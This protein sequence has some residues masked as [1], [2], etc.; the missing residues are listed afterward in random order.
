MTLKPGTFLQ[1]RYEIL[2]IKGVGGMSVV[3]KARCHKLNRFVAIKVLKEEFAR[4]EAFVAK[5]KMEAQAAASL[6]HPNIVN[7]YDVVDD[8]DL[9]FIVMEYIEGVTLKT[10]IASRK[11]LSPN[12]AVSITMQIAQAINVAHQ[13]HIIHRDIKPQNILITQ[14]GKIKVADFG[15]ARAVSKQTIGK[16]AMGSVH[17]LSPEQAKGEVSDER[18]DIYSLGITM[19]EM[20]TGRVPFEGENAVNIAI[21]QIEKPIT[22]PS[23]YN[24]EISLDIENIIL[25]CV[26]KRKAMRYQ[27]TTEL[28]KDLIATLPSQQKQNAKEDKPPASEGTRQFSSEE[29][30]V[31]NARAKSSHAV[32]EVEDL[33]EEEPDETPESEE[34]K[35]EIFVRE[36]NNR[37]EKI[38]AIAGV[39]MA[40]VIIF[41][42]AFLFF[43]LGDALGLSGGRNGTT[44]STLASNQ[45]PVPDIVGLDEELAEEKLKES[46]LQIY[47]EKE[48]YSDTY[49][50]GNVISQNPKPDEVVSKYTKVNVVISLGSNKVDITKLGLERMK[51][52]DAKSALESAGFSVHIV[53]EASETVLSEYVIRFTPENPERGSLVT[54]Y[55]STGKPIV[56]VIVP[57]LRNQNE[58]YAKQILKE[59]SLAVGTVRRQYDDTMDKDRVISQDV[60][61][62]SEVDSGTA[63]GFVVSDGADP[64]VLPSESTQESTHATLTA[65]T[66]AQTQ[67]K[68]RY[69]A[70]IDERYNLKNQIGPGASNVNFSVTIRLKQ[71]VNG[72]T[73]YT[74]LMEP[75]K[76]PGD[77]IL[78]VR[79]SVIEGAEG[80]ETGIVEIVKIENDNSMEV[81]Q[82]YDVLFFP[83][84]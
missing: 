2:K 43:K 1:N 48:E 32:T 25:K 70:S 5:F 50:K 81:I 26:Q 84:R 77:T 23:V 4:D 16:S 28:I 8:G 19:Y 65:E 15:I 31:I 38:L 39:I 47:I 6:I 7:M 78:P 60:E 24:K 13:K 54:L 82:S 33:F 11:Q 10:Y 27:N 76:I 44:E 30:G 51:A 73:V 41:V 45:V 21:A 57:D 18:S 63:I 37:M 46:N 62:G 64:E 74:T 66:T 68:V 3:Y 35:E 36:R 12:A 67:T 9:H 55:K 20:L 75:R 61:P 52:V 72:N 83:G 29:I 58:E 40:L 80:V 71:Y 14:E 53:E 79:F 17:Y 42:L 59:E 22:L 49:E 69:T 56:K 34:G